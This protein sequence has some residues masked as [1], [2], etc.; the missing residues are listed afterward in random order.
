[1][2]MTQAIERARKE[3]LSIIERCD[4]ARMTSETLTSH[5]KIKLHKATVQK[6][7]REMVKTGVIEREGESR[8]GGFILRIKK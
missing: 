2:I 1:M 4:G 5:L 3:I 6:I 8:S 7:V